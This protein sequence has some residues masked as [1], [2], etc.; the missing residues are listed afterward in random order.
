[1]DFRASYGEE[2][3]VESPL[4][5]DIFRMKNVVN[6]ARAGLAKYPQQLQYDGVKRLINRTL[7]DQGLREPLAQGQ[8]RHPWKAAHGLR[9]FHY[10]ALENARVK[11]LN[12]ALLTDH[13]TGTSKDNYRRQI[14]MRALQD[15]LGAV[16][17][18]TIGYDEN[19]YNPNK[20]MLLQKQV[21][22]AR[23]KSEQENYAILGKLAEKDKQ[24]DELQKQQ[25]KMI[26][27]FNAEVHVMVRNTINQ[28]LGKI[29]KQKPGIKKLIERGNNVVQCGSPDVPIHQE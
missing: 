25:Q 2:I 23:E 16:D 5:R 21:L 12:V 4:I 26:E 19:D 20:T 18:L 22:Q 9:K 10:T 6:S 1:M 15:Y 28:E 29:E 17:E 8:R 24:I 3:T 7:W 11:E 13:K 14:E 27:F